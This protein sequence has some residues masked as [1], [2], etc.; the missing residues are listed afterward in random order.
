M[1]RQKDAFILVHQS[2]RYL[3]TCLIVVQIMVLLSAVINTSLSLGLDFLALP[4]MTPKANDLM[5]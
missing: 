4:K 1:G 2:R 3:M 5:T